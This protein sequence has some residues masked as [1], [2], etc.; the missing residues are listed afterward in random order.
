MSTDIAP[1]QKAGLLPTAEHIQLFSQALQKYGLSRDVNN[2]DK[3][4]SQFSDMAT[5]KGDYVLCRQRE[6]RIVARWLRD[7]DIPVRDKYTL[8]MAPVS[9]HCQRAMNTLRRFAI[10]H[11]AG[12]ASGLGRTIL[13]PPKTFEHMS[14][15]C[16]VHNELE[17]FLWLHNKFPG[18][19]VEQQAALALKEQAIS[20]I[21]KGLIETERLRLDHCYIKRDNFVR[22][23]YRKNK[24]D[25]EEESEWD[26]MPRTDLADI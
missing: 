10:K 20:Y 14:N 23:A 19:I 9:T 11:A 8:T 24:K 25:E 13:K 5:I 1:I 4:L 7:L 2:L 16:S 26:E 17:L 12:E 22:Q 6:M 18:N 21:S 15:L 3:I